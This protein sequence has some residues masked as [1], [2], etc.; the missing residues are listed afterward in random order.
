MDANQTRGPSSKDQEIEELKKKLIV[1]LFQYLS[2]GLFGDKDEGDDEVRDDPKHLLQRFVQ[3]TLSSLVA[4]FIDNDRNGSIK[5]DNT[6]GLR[7]TGPGKGSGNCG[8][9]SLCKSKSASTE[10]IKN[11]PRR[12]FFSINELDKISERK[13]VADFCLNSSKNKKPYKVAACRYYPNCE[14]GKGCTYIHR[15]LCKRYPDCKYGQNCY[16]AH[17]KCLKENCIC[18]DYHPNETSTNRLVGAPKISFNLNQTRPLRPSERKSWR[19][20]SV[21]GSE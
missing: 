17:P 1:G 15:G 20:N 7:T 14:K 8:Q 4:N 13:P 11:N 21:S 3:F 5:G 12:K 9:T 10:E 16:Y 18:P 19:S 6:T 2:V